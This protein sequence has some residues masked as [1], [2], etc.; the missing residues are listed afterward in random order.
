MGGG[1][2]TAVVAAAAVPAAAGPRSPTVELHAIPA[3]ADLG[4]STPLP[5]LAGRANS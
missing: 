4:K 3:A 5:S 2:G 1:G